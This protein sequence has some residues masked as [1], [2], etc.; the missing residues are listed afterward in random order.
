MLYR[1]GRYGG[2]LDLVPELVPIYVVTGHE[3]V[4]PW[5]RVPDRYRPYYDFIGAHED[6]FPGFFLFEHETNVLPKYAVMREM[7]FA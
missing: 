2:R 4:D 1:E 7:G 6:I 3:V 5:N